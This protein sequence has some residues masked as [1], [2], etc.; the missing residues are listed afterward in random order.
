MLTVAQQQD[1][2]TVM[3]VGVLPHASAQG[4]TSLA[5]ALRRGDARLLRRRLMEPLYLCRDMPVA[6]CCPLCWLVWQGRRGVTVGEV[7]DG[8]QALCDACE[9]ATGSKMALRSVVDALDGWCD[10]GYS[11][12]PLPAGELLAEVEQELARRAAVEEGTGDGQ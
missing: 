10:G 9:A 12:E 6:C 7:Y 11:A 4:L 5:D 3:K 8:W 1:W 2:R